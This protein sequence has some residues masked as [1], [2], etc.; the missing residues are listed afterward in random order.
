M[1]KKKS[2]P[3]KPS[4]RAKAKVDEVVEEVEEVEEAEEVETEEESDVPTVHAGVEMKVVGADTVYLRSAPRREPLTIAK[5]VS[6]GTIV[7][8]VNYVSPMFAKVKY[9]GKEYFIVSAF[10]TGTK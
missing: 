6:S 7:E 1:S 10:I 2:A 9:E 4:P 8:L 3:K 5:I